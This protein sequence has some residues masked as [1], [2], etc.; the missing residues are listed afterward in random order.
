MYVWTIYDPR[1]FIEDILYNFVGPLYICC[2]NQYASHLYQFRNSALHLNF[3][4]K[5]VKNAFIQGAK[6]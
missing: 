3:H 4:M 1:L 2:I 5:D 6:C